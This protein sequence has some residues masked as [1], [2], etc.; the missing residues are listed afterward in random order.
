MLEYPDALP[1]F[2]AAILDEIN[3]G[4]APFALLPRRC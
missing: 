2:S 3:T 4:T 1:P